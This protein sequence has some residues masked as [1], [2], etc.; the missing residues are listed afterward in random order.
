[1]GRRGVSKK[2]GCGLGERKE[3]EW[4]FT[5]QPLEV[6]LVFRINSCTQQRSF[7]RHMEPTQEGTGMWRKK[8]GQ[9][10]LGRVGAGQEEASP[11]ETKQSLYGVVGGLHMGYRNFLEIYFLSD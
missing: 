8:R 11:L 1:M 3:T 5:L 10:G 9:H 6:A 4:E 2:P 7:T